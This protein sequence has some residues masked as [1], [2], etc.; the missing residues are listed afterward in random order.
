MKATRPSSLK[1]RRWRDKCR[2]LLADH[3][4][5][6]IGITLEP[7]DVRLRALPHKRHL[8]IKQ[9]SDHTLRAYKDLCEGVRVTFKAVPWSTQTTLSS[10]IDQLQELN[11]ELTKQ[12]SNLRDCLTLE[13]EAKERLQAELHLLNETNNLL[14]Q[15]VQKRTREC[16][17]FKDA[18]SKY[19]EGIRKVF[20][21][22][23]GLQSTPTLTEDGCF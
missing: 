19:A 10:R 2:E 7:S 23:Q 1:R 13:T 3:I 15:E 22:I 17:Y 20:P 4:R 18:S 5:K 12:I 8:F 11:A 21:I 6:R 9:L 14:R 16:S